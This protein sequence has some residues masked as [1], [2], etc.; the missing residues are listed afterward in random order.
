MRTWS[1][2]NGQDHLRACS[3]WTSQRGLQLFRSQQLSVPSSFATKRC[4]SKGNPIKLSTCSS[5]GNS[6]RK[7]KKYHSDFVTSSQFATIVFCFCFLLGSFVFIR[8]SSCHTKTANSCVQT[9]C[10]LSMGYAYV[11]HVCILI[12]NTYNGI[13]NKSSFLIWRTHWL[14][15]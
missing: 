8:L 3:H 14:T 7:L 2:R 6:P 12:L 5:I 4:N 1:R 13:T 10:L 15:H 11:C 9:G